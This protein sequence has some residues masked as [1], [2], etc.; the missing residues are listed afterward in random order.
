MNHFVVSLLFRMTGENLHKRV[1]SEREPFQDG[2]R[3]LGSG[4]ILFIVG[5][6]KESVNCFKD[7]VG[8]GKVIGIFLQIHRAVLPKSCSK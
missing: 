5:R 6:S 7:A 2:G 8:A 1:S 4:A 3:P